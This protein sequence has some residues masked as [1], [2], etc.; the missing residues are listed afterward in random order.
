MNFKIDPDV[1]A[2]LEFMQTNIP[3]DKLIGVSK[4]VQ[5]MAQILWGHYADADVVVVSMLPPAISETQL[6]ANE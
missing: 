2:V 5:G 6:A 1:Q 4:G 3:A